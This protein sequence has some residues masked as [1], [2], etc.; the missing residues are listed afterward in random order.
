M[1]WNNVDNKHK[2]KD[3]RNFIS[4][5]ESYERTYI[6]QIVKEEFPSLSDS[7]VDSAISGCCASV[8]APR[9]RQ[10]YWN[11]LKSKLGVG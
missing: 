5:E 11:C 7:A 1:S 2:K 3:D 4:C 10:A 9:P 8:P 6:K